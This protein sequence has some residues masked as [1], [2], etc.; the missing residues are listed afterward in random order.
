[1]VATV[2]VVCNW[3]LGDGR[4]SALYSMNALLT[5]SLK[6]SLW[7]CC[8]CMVSMLWW[9]VGISQTFFFFLLECMRAHAC[10][11]E[12][13]H[14]GSVT[15]LGI[16]PVHVQAPMCTFK[17]YQVLWVQSSWSLWLCHITHNTCI[18]EQTNTGSALD[19]VS[20]ILIHGRDLLSRHEL[21]VA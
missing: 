12:H 19:I 7:V 21:P 6:I 5:N 13:D 14:V 2:Q 8:V 17:Y 16:V 18:A 1:M 20:C 11:H 3:L 9:D 15:L 4:Q 10:G